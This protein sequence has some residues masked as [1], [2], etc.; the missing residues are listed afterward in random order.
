[1]VPDGDRRHGA[2]SR[3]VVHEVPSL[4]RDQEIVRVL[5]WGEDA[6]HCQGWPRR[7]PPFEG[8]FE[9]GLPR[10]GARKALPRGRIQLG[11]VD[12]RNVTQ[13]ITD[14]CALGRLTDRA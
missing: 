5:V 13:W 12:Q 8:S 10:N 14:A 6:F 4:V 7:A 11:I 3:R 1:M 9:G 2:K